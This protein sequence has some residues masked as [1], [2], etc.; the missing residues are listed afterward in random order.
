[1]AKD[2]APAK[3][4]EQPAEEKKKGLPIKTIGIVVGL[5]VVEAAGMYFVLGATGKPKETH[6]AEVEGSHG[7]AKGGGHGDGHGESGGPVA[8]V[9]EI[10]VL[11]DRLPNNSTGRPWIWDTEIIV[12]VKGAEGEHIKAIL[13]SRSA[14]IRTGLG[15]IWRTAQHAHFNEPG[16]ETLTRLATAFLDDLLGPDPEGH[17]YLKQVLIARCVG[18]PTDY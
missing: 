15:R 7:A 8:E 2:Q 11:K 14:E 3:N 5:L 13:E 4:A 6:A 17:S 1:M 12:Q 16:L 18:Y 10:P 9:M